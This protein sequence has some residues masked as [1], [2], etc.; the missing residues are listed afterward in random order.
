MYIHSITDTEKK[1]QKAGN[2]E[3]FPTVF[4][5]FLEIRIMLEG[6]YMRLDSILYIASCNSSRMFAICQLNK[7]VC[8]SRSKYALSGLSLVTIQ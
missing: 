2:E 7:H 4:D 3:Y 6:Q 8:K 1:Y 5:S